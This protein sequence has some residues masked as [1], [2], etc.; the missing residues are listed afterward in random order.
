MKYIKNYNKFKEDKINE[1]FSVAYAV[2]VVVKAVGVASGIGFAPIS[3]AVGVAGLVGLGAYGI[4]RWMTSGTKTTG[5]DPIQAKIIMGSTSGTD[6]YNDALDDFG[7][8]WTN[9]NGYGPDSRFYETTVGELKAAFKKD[10]SKILDCFRPTKKPNIELKVDKSGNDVTDYLKVGDKEIVNDGRLVFSLTDDNQKITAS[11]NGLLALKRLAQAGSKGN[12]IDTGIV[13]FEAN[14]ENL[15]FDFDF[16]PGSIASSLTT[17]DILFECAS[18]TKEKFNQKAKEK[19]NIKNKTKY[20]AWLEANGYKSQDVQF[21]LLVSQSLAS[22]NRGKETYIQFEKIIGKPDEAKK[23]IKSNIIALHQQFIPKQLYNDDLKQ[24]P[25][26]FDG[27]SKMLEFKIMTD[28][29]IDGY[30]ST[31]SKTGELDS[32]ALKQ[33]NTKIVEDFKENFSKFSK[34]F[35]DEKTSNE[36]ITKL[37]TYLDNSNPVK[38]VAESVKSITMYAENIKQTSTETVSANTSEEGEEFGEGK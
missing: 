2:P 19:F 36:A 28:A 37:S 29:E 3:L 7:L 21:D 12:E 13:D 35:L 34:H 31:F 23:L 33:I 17:I 14:R 27:I 11:G 24:F 10:Q 22:A 6:C 20:K 16:K 30:I 5:V 32:E 25:G 15:Y 38:T 1:E 26:I 18:L 8:K 4:Y 9:G